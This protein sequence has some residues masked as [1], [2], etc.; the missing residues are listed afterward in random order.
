MTEP[1]F[2]PPPGRPATLKLVALLKAHAPSD[3]V[4]FWKFAGAAVARYVPRE[5]TE[6][7]GY[8]TDLRIMLRALYVCRCD[9]PD[10]AELTD[11]IETALALVEVLNQLPPFVL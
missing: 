9:M 10:D 6:R 3:P 11:R 7:D 4:A 1:T 5:P 8:F 2:P